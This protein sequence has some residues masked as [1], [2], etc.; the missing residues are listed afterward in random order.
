MC[1][2]E[3][4]IGMHICPVCDKIG[5]FCLAFYTNHLQFTLYYLEVHY[6]PEILA[7]RLPILHSGLRPSCLQTTIASLVSQ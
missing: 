5:V 4:S 3:Q 2:H 1:M 6:I 7:E